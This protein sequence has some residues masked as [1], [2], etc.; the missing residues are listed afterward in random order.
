M[1]DKDND[2]RITKEEIMEVL[3]LEK[4]KEKDIENYIKQVDINGD[5]II[6]YIEFLQLMGCEQGRI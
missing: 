5:G 3:R 6:D 2:G 4:D 1:L